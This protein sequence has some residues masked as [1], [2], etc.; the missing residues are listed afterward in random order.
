MSARHPCPATR[1]GGPTL[2][3]SRRI[4]YTSLAVAAHDK[5]ITDQ[6]WRGLD[7]GRKK[8]L[9]P[10]G[11]DERLR[12]GAQHVSKFKLTQAST[13]EY[14]REVLKAGGGARQLR[15]TGPRLL[16]RVKGLCSTLDKAAV[17]R[18][19]TELRKDMPAAERAK[20]ADEMDRLKDVFAGL[21]RTL[22]G[23]VRRPS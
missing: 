9:L 21:S 22:R 10:L 7:A 15:L 14:V 8:L 4:L 20:I 3:I 18:R 19:V 23:S 6:A 11:T 16:A 2:R 12:E 13:R 17:I 5:R 1:A